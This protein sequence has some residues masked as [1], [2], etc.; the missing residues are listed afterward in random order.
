[1]ENVLFPPVRLDKR[2][3]GHVLKGKTI[4]ITG[5]SSGIGEK[6]AYLL[7]GLEV[8]LILVARREE[9]LLAIKRDIEDSGVASVDVISADLRNEEEM[10]A[11]LAVLGQLPSGLD[12]VVSNAGLSIR[13]PIMDSLGRF[14]DFTRTMAINYFAPVRLLLAVIPQLVR[15]RGQVINVSTINTSLVP[16]PHWAAYQA[17]KTAFDTWL[18]S[19]MLEWQALGV[20]V[21]AIYLPL[22]RTPM[23]EPTDAYRNMPAMSAD[24]AARIIA[25]SMITRQKS[26]KPW[27]HIFGQLASL[28]GRGLSERLMLRMLKGKGD[29]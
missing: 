5:A 2:K 27:W 12:I 7:G 8:R 13:R 21:T 19:A 20:A 17:S 14:H 6:L 22:V 23:I 18:R 11:L 16:L 15:N 25:R 10:A 24:N 28:L 3:L 29:R 1:M 4:L 9:R 26:W